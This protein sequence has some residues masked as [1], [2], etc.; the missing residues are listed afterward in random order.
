MQLGINLETTG[1]RSTSCA[2]WASDYTKSELR[3]VSPQ[4]P[5][6]EDIIISAEDAWDEAGEAEEKKWVRDSK[7]I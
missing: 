2:P 5:L 1:L 6:P 4:D 3:N 7:V